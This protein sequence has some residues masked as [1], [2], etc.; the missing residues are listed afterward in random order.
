MYGRINGPGRI[1][2]LQQT[3]MAICTEK[4]SYEELC[5]SLEWIPSEKKCYLNQQKIPNGEATMGVIFC[6]RTTKK[7]KRN[8]KL[9]CYVIMLNIEYDKHVYTLDT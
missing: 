8:L 4:C 9:S 2:D 3:T 1:E 6:S 7:S 5:G